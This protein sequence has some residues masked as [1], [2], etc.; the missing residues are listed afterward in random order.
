MP[1][2]PAFPSPDPTCPGTPKKVRGPR[3]NSPLPRPSKLLGVRPRLPYEA[4]A[5]E[6]SIAAV[7]ALTQTKQVE[8][9]AAVGPDATGSGLG[10]AGCT[11]PSGASWP[12][13][14]VA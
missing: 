2:P 6:H 8:S 10:L 9:R 1:A 7:W 11:C 5:E 12:V 14:Q 4:A 3:A 13:A